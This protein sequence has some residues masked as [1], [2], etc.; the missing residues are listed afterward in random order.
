MKFPVKY[1][2][3]FLARDVGKCDEYKT[4]NNNTQN[5]LDDTVRILKSN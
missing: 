2:Q 5:K 1:T 3:F 4:N